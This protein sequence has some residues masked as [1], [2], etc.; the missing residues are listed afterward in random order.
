L[1]INPLKTESP[2]SEPQ[3]QA[4]L[5]KMRQQY[6]TFAVTFAS[7]NKGSWF[8]A[9]DVKETMPILDT[10]IAQ[11]AACARSIE[12]HPIEGGIRFAAFS[13]KFA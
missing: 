12:E 5:Q 4:L 6:T 10:L 3:W 11:M 7:L 13:A 9:A 1:L 2:K 8:A